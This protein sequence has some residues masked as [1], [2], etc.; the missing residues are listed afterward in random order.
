MF[1]P[2]LFAKRDYIA[3]NKKQLIGIGRAV[4]KATLFMLNN[5]EAAIR[6]H[7]KL[8]PEQKPKGISEEAALKQG[9]RTL[10]V[11]AKGLV[12][13]PGEPKE[14]GRYTPE[15]WAAY[16]KVYGLT[17]KIPDSSK[18]YTNDL[19]AEINNFDQQKVIEQAKN[20]RMQ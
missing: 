19:V 3:A 4:A 1:G 8:Y 18:F 15:S 12:F 10:E 2:G 9:L 16:L 7:W 14:W 5:P 17:S 11:Q 13:Q 20:F 6:I